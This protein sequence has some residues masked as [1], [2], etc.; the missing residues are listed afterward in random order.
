[1]YY[2]N[3][4]YMTVQLDPILPMNIHA[5]NMYCICYLYSMSLE[6]DYLKLK[7]TTQYIFIIKQPTIF[8]LY[9]G[10]LTDTQWI[11]WIRE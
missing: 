10:Y 1:M 7:R 6:V 2:N 9:P 11:L 5:V 3:V 4:Y 8:S